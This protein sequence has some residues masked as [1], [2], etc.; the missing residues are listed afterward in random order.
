MRTLGCTCMA[1]SCIR[2]C[3]AHNPEELEA[4]MKAVTTKNGKWR[5]TPSTGRPPEQA[6]RGP[7]AQQCHYHGER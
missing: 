5:G 2:V 7:Q 6:P 4:E 3:C 1:L